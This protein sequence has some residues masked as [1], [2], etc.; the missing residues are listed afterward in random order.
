MDSRLD[1][2]SAVEE[3]FRELASELRPGGKLD[4][5]RF[6]CALLPRDLRKG[7]PVD[8]DEPSA[9]DFHP[10]GGP[11]GHLHDSSRRGTSRHAREAIAV[12]LDAGHG[13]MTGPL[14]DLSA[15]LHA[16]V[17]PSGGPDLFR[18][19]SRLSGL[20]ELDCPARR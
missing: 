4:V 3:M 5:Q 2:I 6:D 9:S 17:R 14:Q 1:L 16:A 12:S 18:S 8:V 20:R 13:L 15:C 11:R 19:T 10:G 7:H